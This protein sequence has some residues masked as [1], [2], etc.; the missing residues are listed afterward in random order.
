MG[1]VSGLV[2]AGEATGRPPLTLC[3]DRDENV[4]S[5][6]GATRVVQWLYQGMRDASH[7][8]RDDDDGVMER[9]F[10]GP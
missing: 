9:F 6:R 8:L 5:V 2:R 7:V 4:T 1:A 3:F 10:E